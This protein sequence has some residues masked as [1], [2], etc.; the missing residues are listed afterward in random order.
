[1]NK[2]EKIIIIE[3]SDPI[4]FEEKVNYYLVDEEEQ[5]TILSSS[6]GFVNS[7]SYGFCSSYQS[8]LGKIKK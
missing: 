5:W 1:M 6:I 7:E 4:R 3:E 2:V 8:I